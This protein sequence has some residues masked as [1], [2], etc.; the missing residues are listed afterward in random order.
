MISAQEGIST[1][2]IN[3]SKKT[4][5][6]LFIYNKIIMRH[7]CIAKQNKKITPSAKVIQNSNVSRVWQ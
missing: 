1:G 6:V 5:N 7:A 3:L 2:Y 4:I